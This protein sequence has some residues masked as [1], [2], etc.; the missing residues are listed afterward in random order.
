FRGP[1]PGPPPLSGPPTTCMARGPAPP[2]P[3]G[4]TAR[5]ATLVVPRY[6]RR[7]TV[8]TRPPAAG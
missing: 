6:G 8:M 2:A 5:R 4:P 7:I 3:R 1:P